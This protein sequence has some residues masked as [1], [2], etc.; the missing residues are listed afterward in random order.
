MAKSSPSLLQR[1]I[2]NQQQLLQLRESAKTAGK[3]VVHC[4]GCFDIVHPG[5]IH[6]LQLAKTYGDILIVTVSADTQVNKGLNRPLIPDDL[7]AQSL[8]ALECV[9]HVYINSDPT[10]VELL[11]QLKPDIYVKGREYEHNRDPRFLAEKDCVTRNG[12]KVVCSSGDVIFSSTAL[13]EQLDNERTSAGAFLHA[14]KLRRLR[15][16]QGISTSSLHSTVEKFRD[17]KVLVIGDYILDRYHFCEATGVAGESPMMSLRT[18]DKRDYDGGAAVIALHLAGL[19]AR[20][21]LITTADNANLNATQSRLT[22]AGVNVLAHPRGR[23]DVVKN[24]Y[25]V[26][27]IK[28]MKVDEGSAAPLDSQAE[29]SMADWILEAADGVDAVIFSDFGYGTITG[30]LLDRVMS[31]LRSKVHIIT[32]DVSGR[33]SN[34]LRFKNADI[35]CPTEREA[36]ET[37]HD[38]SSSLPAVIWNLLNNTDA[39]GALVTLGKQGLITFERTATGV[40]P[41]E[42]QQQLQGKTHFRLQS[43]YIPA[44]AAHAVDPLGCGD[45]LL[46][47]ATLALAAGAS[48]TTAAYLGS[49]AAAIHVQT[50]GNTPINAEQLFDALQELDRGKYGDGVRMSA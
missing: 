18:L 7:R 42:I 36:R 50:P 14:E 43:E 21:T 12:G 40:T 34:L 8:A 15:D 46:A 47:T 20:P 30:G 37:L 4:H 6:H 48:M 27:Q 22:G 45:S 24:R 26:D 1:K 11:E 44:L 49:L 19:G 9:D 39:R 25:L 41:T 3:T 23:A 32:A 29:K 13:I 17:L 10:A 16:R 33:Q 35:L 31:T 5:H 38:F 28:M 2:C